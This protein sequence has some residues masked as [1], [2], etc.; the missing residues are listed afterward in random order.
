MPPVVQQ[1]GAPQQTLFQK[2]S[3]G[4]A[5]GTGV[6]LCI[7]FIGGAFQIL[8]AGPGPRGTLATLGQFMGTSAAT[9]GFFMSI[10]TVIR[11]DSSHALEARAYTAASRP[12]L[13]RPEVRAHLRRREEE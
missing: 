10:G 4:A 13:L 5:M 1:P 11:T 7:G 8:R 3:M 9:F 6:G 2:L 12:M